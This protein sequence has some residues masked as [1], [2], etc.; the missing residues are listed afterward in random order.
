MA[1]RVVFA[2][3][4]REGILKGVDKLANTVKITLGPKGKVVIFKKGNPL[5]SLDGVT[6]AK[7]IELKDE[8]EDIGC[9]LVKQIADKTDKEAGDGTTTAILLAQI[10]LKE[11][12]KAIVAGMD[13]IKVKKG[14]EEGL[15]IAT[16]T[17]KRIAKPLKTNQEVANIATIASRDPEIGNT[18]ADIIKKVGKEAIIAVEESR[19]I[20]L[21]T[22]IVQG[23]QFDKGY[24]SPYMMTNPERG[25]VV[26]NGAHILITAQFL[27]SN[28]EIIRLMEQIVRTDSKTLFV[29][30][31]DIAG[32]ALASFVLN[33]MRGVLNI[34]ATKA[35]GYGDDKKETLHDIAILTGA[36]VIEEEAGRK[37]ED[38]ELEDLG[39]ADKVIITKDQTVIIGGKGKKT[40]IQKRIREIERMAEKDESEYY[41]ELAKK[42]LGK[43]KGGVAIIQVGTISEQENQE[44]RYRIEDA[45][46]ATMSA[47]EE[48]IVPGAGMALI[49]CAKEIEKRIEKEKDIDLRMG[50]TI[51]AQAIQ[52]PAAQIIRNAGQKPDV[53]LS[54]TTDTN[55]GYDSSIG[56]YVDLYKAGIIDPA[57]VCRTALENAVSTILLFMVTE[58]CIVEDTIEDKKEKE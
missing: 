20:G 43:M 49:K 39:K 36:T 4:A 21:H 5:F 18:I 33:K 1:K 11:G 17:I 41:R 30:A 44:K 48:G 51:L 28:Q 10:I 6:V 12:M 7:Q 47:I 26:L 14:I 23:L 25:E 54:R 56:E 38:I 31:E 32:E 8:I 29:M 45:V 19:V 35:P 53:I 24:I 42:R 34:A 50:L 37:V 52:E 55:Q 27:K 46:R 2:Q 22:E 15:K 13:M 3:E 9:N 16:D 57:K 40:A 58:A